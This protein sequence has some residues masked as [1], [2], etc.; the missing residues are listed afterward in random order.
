MTRYDYGDYTFITESMQ[1][2]NE[3]L[4]LASAAI[5]PDFKNGDCIGKKI[6]CVGY[7]VRPVDLY[8][9]DTNTKNTVTNCILFDTDGNS[10]STISNGIAAVVCQWVKAG[11]E[12]TWEE[13]LWVEYVQKSKGTY[14]FYS[15]KPCKNR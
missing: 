2:K 9:T 8:D 3:K 12:P 5:N 7:A 14:R 11:V 4:L 6:E 15:L 13:P 10:Y 1:G